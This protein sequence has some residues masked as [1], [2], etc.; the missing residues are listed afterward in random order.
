M[1]SPQR[2]RADQEAP[3]PLPG[4]G[5]GRRREEGP[6]RRG[7]ED[8][9]AASAEDLQLVAEDGILEIQLIEAAAGEHAE[10]PAQGP[11]PD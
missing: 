2:G 11:V 10:Q 5:Q 9:P 4:K 8:S 1:P 6:V 3:P 7:E